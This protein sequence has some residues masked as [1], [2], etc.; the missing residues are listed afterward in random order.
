V[1]SLCLVLQVCFLISAERR[2]PSINYK[3]KALF[4]KDADF[5]LRFFGQVKNTWIE[6]IKCKPHI[7]KCCY[8]TQKVSGWQPNNKN[9]GQTR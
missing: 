2:D 1:V 6:K 4:S 5:A 7:C 3:A 8:G 9:T